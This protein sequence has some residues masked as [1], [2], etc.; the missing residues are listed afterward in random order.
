MVGFGRLVPWAVGCA[1]NTDNGAGSPSTRTAAA[2]AARTS[3]WPDR[4]RCRNPIETRLELGSIRKDGSSLSTRSIHDRIVPHGLLR[5]PGQRA[6]VA[7]ELSE[8]GIDTEETPPATRT[9]ALIDGLIPENGVRTRVGELRT[10]GRDRREDAPPPPREREP[11]GSW[12][13]PRPSCRWCRD[14]TSCRR[15]SPAREDRFPEWRRVPVG[16]RIDM[17]VQQ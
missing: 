12:P 5:H 16:L 6:N 13:R 1:G 10:R 11:R 3:A 7:R 8:A 17:A 15:E 14:R 4:S 9:P 2:W